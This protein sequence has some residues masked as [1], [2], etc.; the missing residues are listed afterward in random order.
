MKDLKIIIAF[1]GSA[2]I[3]SFFA[4][5]FGGVSL[6]WIFLRSIAGSIVFAALGFSLLF[7]L[8]KFLPEIFSSP[9]DANLID[10]PMDEN[11][12]TPGSQVDIVIEDTD[13]TPYQEGIEEIREIDGDENPVE[14]SASGY[15]SSVISD[16]DSDNDHMVEEEGEESGDLPNI[17]KFSE[18]FDETTDNINDRNSLTGSVSVDIMGQEQDPGTVAKAIR[19][20]M[21]KDQEG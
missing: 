20:I 21:K 16:S 6:K 19:T 9:N 18:V 14:E 10:I 5:L 15:P 7:I 8:R 12:E 4:G 1:A 2:F 11:G 17:E 3:L 13:A